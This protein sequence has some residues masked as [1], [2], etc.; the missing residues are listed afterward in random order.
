MADVT[1]RQMLEAGVHFGHQTRYW[2]PKMAPFIFGERNKIHIINLEQTLPLYEQAASFVRK[3]VADGGTVMFVGTK[4][5]ARDCVRREAVRCGMPHVTYRWLGGMLTNYKTVKQSIK[6]LTDLEAQAEDGSFEAMNKKEVLQLRREMDKLERSLGGIKAMP[7]LPDALFLIDVGHE[8]I[9]LAEA[10]KLGIPVVAGVD[11]V[12]PGND[13]AMR[14]IELYAVGIA[15]SVIEGK[16]SVPSVPEGTSDFVE[17]DESG[18]PR[19]QAAAPKKKAPARKKPAAKKVKPTKAEAA[20]AVEKASEAEKPEA[21]GA[22]AAK[23]SPAEKVEAE[24]ASDA[25]EAAKKAAPKVEAKPA[26]KAK[27]KTKA[28]A[29]A[30]T[31]TKAKA[32][33]KAKPKTTKAAEATEAKAEAG[34]KDAEPA[35]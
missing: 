24:K 34:D 26:A 4:R 1:M 23:E 22:E 35:A 30:K 7:N 27:A 25:P 5:A 2:N 11:Y 21:A 28:K 29:K 18:K 16:D 10:N 32:K 31:K 3:L 20:E 19:E 13:D 17:L 9:A 8:K 14:A 33:A 15:D 12:I 6:R